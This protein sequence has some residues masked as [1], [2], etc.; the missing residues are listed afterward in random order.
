[1]TDSRRIFD[2]CEM[3]AVGDGKTDCTAVIQKAMDLAGACGG[4][5][6]IAPGNY[7][8]GRLCVRAGITICGNA[9][10]SYGAPGGSVLT[11][12]DAHA[13][14]LLDITGCLLYTSP[15]PRDS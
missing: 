12:N 14:C 8:T 11:L 6:S 5:V 15:S 13:S 10:W 1:M 9:A 7:L 3:G 2:I 4:V